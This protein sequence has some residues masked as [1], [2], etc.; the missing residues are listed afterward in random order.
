[1]IS[2]RQA[3]V[4]PPW[5][6]DTEWVL[7]RCCEKLGVG[8]TGSMCLVSGD[9]VVPARTRVCDWPGIRASGEISEYQLVVQQSGV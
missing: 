2:G 4:F 1:M 9:D 5:S 3:M 6:R 8:F 7:R